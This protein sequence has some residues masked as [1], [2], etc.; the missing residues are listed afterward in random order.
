MEGLTD[1]EV[2][3]QLHVSRQY[4]HRMRKQYYRKDTKTYVVLII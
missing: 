1:I 4:V 2:A 3:N